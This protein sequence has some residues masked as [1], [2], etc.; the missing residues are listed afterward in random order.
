MV[1][2]REWIGH[3]FAIYDQPITFSQQDSRRLTSLTQQATI[4]LQNIRL[5]AESQQR[6][7]QLLTAAEIARS[8]SE[9]LSQ[10]ELLYRAINLVRRTILTFTMRPF[11]LLDDSRQWAVVEESTGEAGKEMKRRSHR[12]EVGSQ[13][14]IGTVTITGEP[15]VIND[16]NKDQVHKQNPLLPETRAELGIPL[17]L[18]RR[19]I[20]ALDV[21]STEVDAFNAD[22]IAVLQILADQLAIAIDNSRSYNI[23]QE[24]VK[25]AN[26]RIEEM[27]TLFEVS[28]SL[29]SAPC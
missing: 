10:Q 12:L 24:A 6:A 2:A 23:A 25:D 4:A 3:I 21:Q 18:G 28:Q 14:I 16:V 17:K 22:D 20:G 11:F 19:I 29:S 26:D 15:L 5:L 8:A 13:S 9:T 7:S 27:S 1:V